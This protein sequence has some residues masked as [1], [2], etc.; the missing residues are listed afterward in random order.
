[1]R[2]TTSA[3]CTWMQNLMKISLLLSEVISLRDLAKLWVGT[4]APNAQGKGAGA[5]KRGQC[6]LSPK[7]AH[8]IWKQSLAETS[9]F[10]ARQS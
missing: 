9:P 6:Q 5:Q 7:S 4:G 10:F 1:M 8:I 3:W 2:A